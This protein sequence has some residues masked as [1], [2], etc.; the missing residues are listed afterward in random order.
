MEPSSF[1]QNIGKWNTSK[2]FTNFLNM[3]R[4]ASAFNQDISGWDVSN[5][6]KVN[7]LFRGAKAFNQ[8]ISS[9]KLNESIKFSK[10]IFQD[11]SSFDIENHSPFN[12]IK[13]TTKR[14]SVA[15]CARKFTWN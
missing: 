12:E 8:D 5:V 15:T 6:K 10:T 14:V 3:F 9:W 4:E 7:G 2:Y 1:N 13:S 11:A